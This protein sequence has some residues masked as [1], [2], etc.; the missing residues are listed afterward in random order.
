MSTVNWSNFDQ[1]VVF[2][3][4]SKNCLFT[5]VNDT[6]KSMP[7]YQHNQ[8]MYTESLH[9]NSV[10][11][12]QEQLKQQESSIISTKNAQSTYTTKRH[13]KCT[14]SDS[15]SSQFFAEPSSVVPAGTRRRGPKK[16]PDSQERVVRMKMRRARA[17]ARE[18]S[19]MHGLNSALDTLRQHI[20]SALVSGHI[21]IDH[22]KYSTNKNTINIGQKQ[23]ENNKLLSKSQQNNNTVNLINN[24]TN[25]N[26]NINNLHQFGQKLSKIET[27]RLACNYIGLLASIL[28]DIHFESITDIIKY[29]CHGLSQITTNQ[30][31]AALQNDP[32]R[33]M[34]HQVPDNNETVLFNDNKYKSLSVS[35]SSSPTNCIN[36]SETDDDANHTENIQ[37]NI[38]R[39]N[40]LQNKL[41]DKQIINQSNNVFLAIPTNQFTSLSNFNHSMENSSL[42]YKELLKS[43]NYL[44]NNKSSEFSNSYDYHQYDMN[45]YNVTFPYFPTNYNVDNSNI[46]SSEPNNLKNWIN[47]TKLPLVDNEQINLT[48]SDNMNIINASVDSDQSNSN[49]APD[50]KS[51]SY[52]Y[53]DDVYYDSYQMMNVT[54]F[55]TTDNCETGYTVTISNSDISDD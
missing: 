51:C 11:F 7:R 36:Y 41:S 27:L 25:N 16:K 26:N 30:I 31:A 42:N 10:N 32:T 15:I 23:S 43:Q 8:E 54:T 55:H 45:E 18:R 39:S 17:N 12:L 33:L 40:L 9:L 46:Q 47:E 50:L 49:T 20:P 19:R 3:E 53:T 34:K 52:Y 44:T 21:T 1:P 6:L 14:T 5:D 22:I 48:T 4:K 24:N 37:Q 13:Q 28:N 29:L 38:L 2:T 35:S